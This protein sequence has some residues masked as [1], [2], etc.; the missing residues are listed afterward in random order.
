VRWEDSIRRDSSLLLSIRG[1][2]RQAVDRTLWRRSN[3]RP[4]PETGCCATDEKEEEEEEDEENI[5][6]SSCVCN[7]SQPSQISGSDQLQS[8]LT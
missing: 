4:G 8:P 1:W 7:S 5:T 2:K 6:I 3:E